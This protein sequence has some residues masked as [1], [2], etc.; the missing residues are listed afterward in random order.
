LTALVS[1]ALAL[2]GAEGL[3]R[4]V[5]EQPFRALPLH[6]YEPVMYAPDPVLGWSNKPGSYDFLLVGRGPRVRMSYGPGGV[7]DSG[8]PPATPRAQVALLGGSFTQGWALSDPDTLGAKLQRALPRVEIRNYGTG[9]YGTHQS[10]LRMEKLLAEPDAPDFFVYGFAELH[11]TRNVATAGWLEGLARASRSGLTAVPFASLDASGRLVRH[12]PESWPRWP[13]RE[14]LAVSAF[15]ERTSVQL[16]ARGR[17]TQARPVTRELLLAMR[18][19][20]RDNSTGLL[21]ALLSAPTALDDHRG[22]LQRE[23]V[24]SVDCAVTLTPELIVPGDGH[25]NAKVTS[26]WS[27]CIARALMARL[28]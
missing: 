26:R 13:L 25:P 4:L 5:G 8:T 1:L 18:D 7:R 23:R 12:P 16:R 15:A 20:A 10:L 27:A 9:G 14:R 28:P 19:T 6:L 21:V 24:D 3:L 2:A 17:E 11:E 22:F